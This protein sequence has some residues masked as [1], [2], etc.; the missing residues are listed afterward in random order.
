MAASAPGAL[1][2]LERMS[3]DHEETRMRQFSR[4]DVLRASTAIAASG[5]FASVTSAAPPA[6]AVTPELIAAA[7]KEGKVVYYTSIDLPVAERLAKAFEATYPGIA[8]RVERTG[9]E[10][11]FQRIGQEYASRIHSVDVVNSSDA[12]HFVVWKREGMLEPYVPEDVAKYYPAEHKDP[13]GTFASFRVWLCVIG[14]NTTMVKAEEAPTSYADLLDP[15]WTSKIVKAHP[16]YSGTI[17]TA[18]FQMARDL[19]WEY[20][21]K[22]AKQK[23]MQVQSAT[24]PPKKLA[25]GERAVMA[26]GG[27]YNVLQSKESGGP[28]EV[29]YP[30]EGTPLVVGPNGVFKNAPNPNAARLFQCYCFTQ[31]CQQLIVD[32]GALRSMHP[33]VKEKAGRKPFRDIKTMK[34]DAPGV[35]RTSEEIKARYSRLFG[36]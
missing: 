26:D 25:L 20:F 13:D 4:R 2:R 3:K 14:Y 29:V 36:V 9:A 28:I 19:G 11:V 33:L 31:E 16:S 22:L 21:E 15:K 24:D 34:E 1:P 12:A 10:R 6:S 5:A 27:E 30:T 7:K 18:T 32:F 17:M 23:V 35:E 8:V